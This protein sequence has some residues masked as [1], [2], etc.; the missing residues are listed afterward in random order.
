MNDI[1]R[2]FTH[3]SELIMPPSVAA[4]EMSA[5]NASPQIIP[6]AEYFEKYLA[7]C[8][9]AVLTL[10]E[11]DINKMSENTGLKEFRNA[12]ATFM[13]RFH[14]IEVNPDQIIV[15][16]GLQSILGN[17]LSLPSIIHPEGIPK[18]EGLLSRAE[19][20]ASGV[21][22]IVAFAEDEN[23]QVRELF[24]TSK[25]KIKD[26]AVDRQII[27]FDSLL[28]SGATLLYL[29]PRETSV[30]SAEE[31]E[32]RSRDFLSWASAA[33]YRFII[34]YD[35]T[36][37]IVTSCP[38]LKKHDVND[39]VIYLNSFSSLLCKGISASWAVLPEKLCNEYKE[40]FCKFPCQLSYLEQIVLAMFV[41]KGYLDNYLE[42]IQSSI[43]ED[44][45]EDELAF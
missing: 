32:E 35:D 31:L 2:L 7:H 12:L 18:Q 34:E 23:D 1:E 15:G 11:T 20:I 24:A 36:K 16:S 4:E 3:D 41:E 28:S 42:I 44:E 27:S 5:G 17:I 38:S 45:Q 30:V 21:R 43:E 19:Q 37:K 26:V 25:I 40:K 8:Y 29:T 22:P 9:N 6:N 33:P 10:G 13:L 39:N 14:G